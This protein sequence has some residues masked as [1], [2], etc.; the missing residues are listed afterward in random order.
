M[1]TKLFFWNVRGLNNPNKHNPFAQ[2]IFANK[3]IFGA[4]LETHIKEPQLQHVMSKTCPGWNYA[5]NHHSDADG[6]IVLIWKG[7]AKVTIINQTRQTMICELATSDS[8]KFIFTA[9]YA[10]NTNKERQDLW[11]DLINLHQ[12][13]S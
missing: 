12:T 3:P 1:S 8:H 11:V 5:S 6:R 4:L 9:I 13:L 10:A 2:W 7:P